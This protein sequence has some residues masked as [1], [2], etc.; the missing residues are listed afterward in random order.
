MKKQMD[1]ANRCHVPYVVFV[2]ENEIAAQNLTV[3][4][5]ATGEQQ[6]MTVEDLLLKFKIND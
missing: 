3:K 1:F 4:N 2:G 6:S 5:M